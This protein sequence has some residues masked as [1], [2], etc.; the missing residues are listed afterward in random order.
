MNLPRSLFLLGYAGLV[1]FIAGPLWL[2]LAPGSAPPWL[3]QAWLLYA[4]LLAAFMAGTF[5][6]LALVVAE[7]PAGL[8]GM[9]LSAVL[10]LLA[11]GAALLPF[12]TALLALA[13][14]FLLLA[15]AELW[16][17]RVLDPMSSYFRLRIAL[18]VGVLACIAWRYQL[19]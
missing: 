5:W 14:V 16:R 8:F 18:T 17:E 3:D 12:F 19:G 11:W 9:L 6:G 13:I 1:P 15:L 4:A 7:N 2:T 10:M